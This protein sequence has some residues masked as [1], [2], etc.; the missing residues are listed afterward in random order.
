MI[1]YLNHKYVYKFTYRTVLAIER[2]SVKNGTFDFLNDQ[3]QVAKVPANTISPNA[4]MKKTTQKKPNTLAA[5][6]YGTKAG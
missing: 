4:E 6:K 1:L 5:W 3:Y 2:V